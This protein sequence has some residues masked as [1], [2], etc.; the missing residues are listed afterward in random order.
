MIEPQAQP[1][2]PSIEL[3]KKQ[4]RE[5]FAPLVEFASAP[6]Y[7]LALRMLNDEQDAEDVLQDTF[8]KAYQALPAFEGRSSLKTWLFRIATNEALMLLRKRKPQQAVMEIDR[9]EEAV[10]EPKEIVDW[11][12]I[13]EPELMNLETRKKLEEAASHLSEG[14]RAVF[15][16]RDVEGLSGEE[17]AAI[18]N[19]SVDVVKTRL[20]RARLKLRE[21]LSVYFGERLSHD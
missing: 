4:D 12:C 7:R 3:L 13:P 15:L 19:V 10:E 1:A 14:L 5:A 6:I 20:L 9:E 17:T 18:L 16:L 8:I 21:E 2:E 11:C